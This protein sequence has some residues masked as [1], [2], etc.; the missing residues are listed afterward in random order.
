MNELV[1]GHLLARE[2]AFI[3]SVVAA[4]GIANLAAQ[5]GIRNVQ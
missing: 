2:M 1:R 4:S 5:T 3:L